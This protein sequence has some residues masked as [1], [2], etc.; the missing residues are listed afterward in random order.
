MKHVFLILIGI[1]LLITSCNSEPN[2]YLV[3]KH[4]IG[5][6][7]DSTAV[8]DLASIFSNDS[9]SQFIGGDEFIGNSNIIKVYEKETQILLLELTPKEALDSLSNIEIIRIMDP[10]YKTKKGLNK[11]GTY[12]DISSKYNISGIQNTL[13]NLIVSV[14]GINAYFTIEKSELPE[15]L[16]YDMNQKIEDVSIPH[17]AKI[18]DFFI[19]WN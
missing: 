18:K 14:N 10:R 13:R 19:Q 5:H 7:T 17:Q 1:Y 9:I 3:T 15:I 11:L 2:Q 16:R 6:L 12:K 4:R 8:K